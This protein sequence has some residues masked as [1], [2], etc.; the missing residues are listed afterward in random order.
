ML[1]KCQFNSDIIAKRLY[2][3]KSKYYKLHYY[4]LRVVYVENINI[5][6]TILIKFYV[7]YKKN[8]C[9]VNVFVGDK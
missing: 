9:N 1:S 3:S 5:H 6:F 8:S 4:V 2:F 7:F